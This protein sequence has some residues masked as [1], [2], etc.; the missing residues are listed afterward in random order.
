MKRITLTILDPIVLGQPSQL[1]IASEGFGLPNPR[2]APGEV[3]GW[4]LTA[5]QHV[6]S[7]PEQFVPQPFSADSTGGS[8]QVPRD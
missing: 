7:N 6:L 5:A 1:A 4:L 3:M 2:S 8:L